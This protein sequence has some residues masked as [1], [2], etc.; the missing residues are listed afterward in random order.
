MN[1]AVFAAVYARDLRLTLAAE[2]LDRLEEVSERGLEATMSDSLD[3]AEMFEVYRAHA[4]RLEGCG[5]RRMV[6]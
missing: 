4:N 5:S 3:P 6:A 2:H 1:G